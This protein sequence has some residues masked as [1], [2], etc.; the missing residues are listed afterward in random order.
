MILAILPVSFV[1]RPVDPSE[2]ALAVLLASAPLTSVLTAIRPGEGADTMVF[3][4]DPISIVFRICR[5]HIDTLAMIFSISP[6]P[7][8]SA[9]VFEGKRA[10]AVRIPILPVALK[11]RAIWIDY[12]TYAIWI[13]V[14]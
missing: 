10:P 6:I 2:F 5:G 12:Y 13:P 7:L 14:F 3:A 4:L 9:S 1:H 8:I 11:L